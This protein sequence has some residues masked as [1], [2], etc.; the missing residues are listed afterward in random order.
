MRGFFGNWQ[1]DATVSIP[2]NTN[3]SVG[4]SVD[5]STDGS[6]VVYSGNSIVERTSSNGITFTEAHDSD[7]GSHMISIDTSDN[8][9]VGFY[10]IGNIY[11]V[12]IRAATVDSQVVNH[13]V[14]SFALGQMVGADTE[15]LSNASVTAIVNRCLVALGEPTITSLQEVDNP[16]A[17]KANAIFTSVR[18]SVFEMHLWNSTRKL[19]TLA[20]LTTTPTW[21]YA[22]EYQL[23]SDFIRL[24]S[25][26]DQSIHQQGFQIQGRKFLTDATA[27]SIEYVARIEDP[28]DMSPLLKECISWA[29]A[30]ELAVPITGKTSLRQ[31]MRNTLDKTLGEARHSDATQN[32]PDVISTQEF[33]HSRFSSG[34]FDPYRPIQS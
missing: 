23:P 5:L 31:E 22:K 1:K 34:S 4:A 28:N 14:A 20:Q 11:H 21:G 33:L 24:V 26:K 3:D 30:V 25:I 13:W 7:T 18:D 19:A 2:F 27:T 15:V 17:T 29:L 12:K 10:A 6:I 16:A 8:T 9:D 32:N